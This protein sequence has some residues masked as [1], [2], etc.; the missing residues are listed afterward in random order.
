MASRYPA[1]GVP[2]IASARR[3]ASF[4]WRRILSIALA[5]VLSVEIII[6]VD[7]FIQRTVETRLPGVRNIVID[8]V[9]V[10][11]TPVA[12]TFTASWLKVDRT[13]PTHAL[14][15]DATIWR[16]MHLKKRIC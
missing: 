3:A 11:S 13:V 12:I 7:E 4:P 9:F 10:D 16:R 5:G 8:D 2:S 14:R 1:L 6:V 15:N